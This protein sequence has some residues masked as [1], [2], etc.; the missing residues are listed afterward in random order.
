MLVLAAA[1]ACARRDPSPI[2]GGDPER[3]RQ[4]IYAIGCGTCH[5]IP[6]VVGATGTIGPSLAGIRRRAI[7]AGLLPNTPENM[8]RWI[9][10]PS[11]IQPGVAMPP[12]GNASA[13]VQ[14][15]I[16]AYL[17]TTK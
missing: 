3:G 8:M 2:A 14:R 9:A 11:S 16:V 4:A 1:G 6:G 12:L 15:D 5:S 17:Y 7:I 13:R 10:N